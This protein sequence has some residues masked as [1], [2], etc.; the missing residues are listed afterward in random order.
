MLGLFLKRS[1]FAQYEYLIGGYVEIEVDR[2]DVEF[3]S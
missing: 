3:L 1:F 2:I